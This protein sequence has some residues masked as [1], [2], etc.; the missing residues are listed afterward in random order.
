[1]RRGKL[2]NMSNKK[3]HTKEGQHTPKNQKQVV[4]RSKISLV[5]KSSYLLH[6]KLYLLPYIR[7]KNQHNSLV[8]E[9]RNGYNQK[10][11]WW[12]QLKFEP[13]NPFIQK[14]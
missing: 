3:E 10:E 9:Y 7:Y 11:K 6:H 14:P 5:L 4:A 13:Y 1:M 8:I 2:K 12:L